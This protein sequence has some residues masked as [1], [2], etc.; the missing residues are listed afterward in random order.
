MRIHKFC[1]LCKTRLSTSIIEGLRRRSCPECGWVHYANP[2]PSA[3]A[4]VYTDDKKILLV[5]RGV[6]PGKGKWALP[7]GFVEKDEIPEE[8]VLRELKEEANIRGLVRELLGVYM[9]PTR[10][11]GNVLLIAYDVRCINTRPRAG[12]DSVA[13]KF[14]SIDKIP[15]I[16]F[17]SHRAIIRDGLARHADRGIQIH[18]LKSKITEATI[19][20]THLFYKGSMGIDA[21]VMKSVG[22][23]PG[24]K[25][26]V[27]N[28]DNGE[29]FETYTIEEKP[30][31]GR[32]V[33]YG[34]ASRKGS[35]GQR[36]CILSYA[37][38]SYADA[39]NYRT[40]IVMLN[41]KNR[42]QRV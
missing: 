1:P 21:T 8:T 34:P 38:M 22:M 13:A 12:T 36:L 4:F 14:F 27:L 15:R 29:R 9:E 16:P 31:S 17:T 7:S 11:Y 5:Q 26:H 2:L 41:S 32:I 18:M 20:H 28:Y 35:V 3:V 6:E 23:L 10:M 19:T 24:E 30:R 39:R 37:I 40:R 33:L 25:V 42:I